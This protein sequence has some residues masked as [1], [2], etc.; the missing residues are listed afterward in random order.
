MASIEPATNNVPSANVFDTF[1]STDVPDTENANVVLPANMPAMAVSLTVLLTPLVAVTV[2]A[3]LM[4][5]PSITVFPYPVMVP[6]IFLYARYT[7]IAPLMPV[8]VGIGAR[9][10]DAPNA[11]LIDTGNVDLILLPPVVR[12]LK[13]AV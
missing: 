10:V 1:T 4:N 3:L 7:Y 11:W 8:V 6:V 13:L 2:P 5:F 9:V 12:A